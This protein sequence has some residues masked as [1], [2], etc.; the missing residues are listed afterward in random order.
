MELQKMVCVPPV[1]ANA[2]NALRMVGTYDTLKMVPNSSCVRTEIINCG[3]TPSCSACR[4]DP[5]IIDERLVLASRSLLGPNGWRFYFLSD[6]LSYNLLLILCFCRACCIRILWVI[7]YTYWL[8]QNDGLVQ[9]VNIKHCW[10][11]SSTVLQLFPA[12]AVLL[13]VYN[14]PTCLPNFGLVEADGFS[15]SAGNT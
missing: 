5:H 3:R 11:Y 8:Y 6:F 12:C 13:L 2:L 10:V 7:L 15:G 4:L 14:M 1:V 9:P